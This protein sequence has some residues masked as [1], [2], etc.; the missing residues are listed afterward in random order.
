MG[1]KLQKQEDL[2]LYADIKPNIYDNLKLFTSIILTRH[3]SLNWFH[4]HHQQYYTT[5]THMENT[6]YRISCNFDSIASIKFGRKYKE[7]ILLDQITKQS[8]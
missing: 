7:F 3:D 1:E 5:D 8:I 6:S 2:Y 4:F